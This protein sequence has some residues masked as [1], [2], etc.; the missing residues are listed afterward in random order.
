MSMQTPDETRTASNAG[1]SLSD[2]AKDVT[3][4][5]GDQAKQVA[6]EAKQ[7]AREVAVEAKEQAADL[8]DQARGQARQQAEETT[9]HLASGLHSL[10]GQ[11]QAMREGRTQDAGSVAQYA[12]QA[13]QRIDDMARRLET[14]GLDGVARDLSR[15]ARRRPGVFLLACAGVGF[16]L[17]RLVRAGASASSAGTSGNGAATNGGSTWRTPDIGARVPALEVEPALPVTVPRTGVS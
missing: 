17:A 10:S 6:G 16:A 7:Q 5:A 1:G 8:F 2:T 4:H 14:G 12:D 3:S 15:F 11:I 13:R 9:Q